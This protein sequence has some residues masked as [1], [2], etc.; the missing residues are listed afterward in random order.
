V[1]ETDI[2]DKVVW[3]DVECGAY[4][5]D[6]VLWSELA[7]RTGGERCAVLEL[8]CG[9][10]RVSMALAALKHR[11]TALDTDAE[12][13]EELARRAAEHGLDVETAVADAR[14]F[15][16]GRV[17]DLVLAPMQIVQLLH[18]HEERTAML[19]RVRTH[20]RPGGMA[21]L[22]LLGSGEEWTATPEDA[23]LP[24]IRDEGAWVYSSLPVAVRLVEHGTAIVLDRLRQ[25]VSP[26]WEVHE[27][28]SQIRLEVL[29]P[30]VLEQEAQAVG[31]DPLPSRE[32]APTDDHVGSTVVLLRRPER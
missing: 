30:E 6:L 19:A 24:D 4:S 2:R 7:D 5:A 13:V 18:G 32:I 14:S 8:G 27:E 15:S 26:T 9:T 3:H 20:L 25:T 10:G 31:L 23:P 12:L 28:P 21:A 11:V 1:N 29:P 17:F 22:A 16:L